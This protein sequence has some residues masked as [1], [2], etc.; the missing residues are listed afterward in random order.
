[1][2]YFPAEVNGTEFGKEIPHHLSVSSVWVR[3]DGK[4]LSVFVHEAAVK[5]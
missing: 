5:N 3:R 4:W 1:V 2:L